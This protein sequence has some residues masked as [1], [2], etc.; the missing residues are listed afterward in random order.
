MPFIYFL[1]VVV[2][3]VT[4]ASQ[5]SRSGS[6]MEK[7]IIHFLQVKVNFLYHIC[8]IQDE[9]SYFSLTLKSRSNAKVQV[10]Y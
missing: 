9:K 10:I 4:Y 6:L 5:R 8:N 7:D 1:Y 2:V 3:L